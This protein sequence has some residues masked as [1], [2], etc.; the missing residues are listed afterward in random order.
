MCKHTTIN[1]YFSSG[2]EDDGELFDHLKYYS[3]HYVGAVAQFGKDLA[4]V[5]GSSAAV[6]RFFSQASLICSK[7]RMRLKNKRKRELICLKSYMKFLKELYI[8]YIISNYKYTFK[9]VL[10]NYS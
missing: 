10:Y 3:D 4:V 5:P 9:I 7:K 1:D 6:E 8:A 2:T